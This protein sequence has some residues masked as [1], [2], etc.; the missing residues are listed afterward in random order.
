MK[1]R[2]LKRTIL[3]ALFLTLAP[4]L[5]VAQ[6]SAP[7]N[8]RL[9]DLSWLAGSW[10]GE[11]RGAAP[12][13]RFETH[14]TTPQGGVILSSSKAFSQEGKLSW[15]EFE[16]FETRDGVLQMTPYPNGEASVSFTLTEYDPAT[17]K[18]VFSN[19]QHDHPN[20]ITYQRLAED[21]LLCIVAGNSEG[22][23]VLEVTLSRLP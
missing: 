6:G 20:R 23:P 1:A 4:A 14:Y 8:V 21:R 22:S 16:R 18:A 9:E 11:V 12:G 15:F 17:K 10:S 5:T 3:L 7:A 2:S 19:A 13:T